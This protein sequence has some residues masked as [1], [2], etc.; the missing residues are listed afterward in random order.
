M[1]RYAFLD[2][3]VLDWRAHQSETREACTNLG[4]SGI[5]DHTQFPYFFN[6]GGKPDY[7]YYETILI[8]DSEYMQEAVPHSNKIM[9]LTMNLSP[10]KKA[11]SPAGF[12]YLHGVYFL[13]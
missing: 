11:R 8:R 6:S 13:S 10:T 5:L 7:I 4:R 9:Y 12:D 1:A 3:S 2:A